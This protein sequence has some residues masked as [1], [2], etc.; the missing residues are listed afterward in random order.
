MPTRTPSRWRVWVITPI[1]LRQRLRFRV[2]LE[3]PPE[4]MPSRLRAQ[5]VRATTAWRAATARLRLRPRRTG[6]VPPVQPQPRRTSTR[7]TPMS[8]TGCSRWVG[9]TR[10]SAGMGPSDACVAR[11]GM[12][13]CADA[14]RKSA[15]VGA[16]RKRSDRLRIYRGGESAIMRDDFACAALC[17]L[18]AGTMGLA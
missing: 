17:R 16:V 4:C 2:Q 13:P 3:R 9:A 6:H 7:P 18:G 10:A 8:A 14:L 1:R 11:F 5:S 15:N 12:M